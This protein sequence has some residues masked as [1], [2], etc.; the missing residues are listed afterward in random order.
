MS[1]EYKSTTTA[2]DSRR[3]LYAIPGRRLTDPSPG[4]LS[5]QKPLSLEE[6]ITLRLGV[7]VVD[8]PLGII[9]DTRVLDAMSLPFEV[10]MNIFAYSLWEGE[11]IN[12]AKMAI[13]IKTQG[14]LARR[15][16]PVISDKSY[17]EL[18]RRF[19]VLRRPYYLSIYHAV[20]EGKTSKETASI[21]T[22]PLTKVNEIRK[23]LLT[24]GEIEPSPMGVTNGLKNIRFL[25]QVENLD[26]SLTLQEAAD[27]LVTTRTRIEHA[28]RRLIAVGRIH[29]KTT[30]EMY[31]D[32][33]TVVEERRRKIG[34]LRNKTSLRVE[35]IAKILGVSMAVV[36]T[37]ITFLIINNRIKR[38]R[39]NSRAK[40][41]KPIRD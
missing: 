22:I 27:L 38:K 16:Y 32:V 11:G 6:V 35:E 30:E 13:G 36:E 14:D 34:E 28:R 23:D 41:R 10:K 29:P 25:R 3:H 19:N 1:V 17:D 40:N 33:L 2:A 37:D 12:A 31:G 15:A 24:S 20:K 4:E 18:L 9:N 5:G 39:P 8:F 7:G 21:L 26:P